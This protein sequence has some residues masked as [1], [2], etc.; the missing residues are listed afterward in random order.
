L[1]SE[2]V[3]SVAERM[4]RTLVEIGHAMMK[5]QS[6]LEFLWEYA[7]AHATYLRNRS[8]TKFLKEITPYQLW[9]N[10]KPN[11]SH[12]REFSAPVWVVLQGQNIP[13]KMLLKSKKRAY[14][15]YEDGSK[16]IKY[17]NA[18][19]RKILTSR[20]FCFLSNTIQ[21]PPEEI[22]VAPD[23]QHEGELGES[24]LPTGNN[25]LKRKRGIEEENEQKQI[26]HTHRKRVDYCYLND[27]FPD[28]TEE[29]NEIFTVNP[30]GGD[31]PKSLAEAKRSP[32]WDEWEKAV[33]KELDQLTEMGVW[34]LVDKPADAILISNRWV[35]AVLYSPPHCPVG[36]R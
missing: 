16:S 32:E 30:L 27:P 17:Y 28:E 33:T 19:T 29:I 14:V 10:L 9:Y 11:V 6:L 13:R 25:S 3:T 18:E 8:Y 7:I 21:S 20:N 22:E 35:F 4:N 36:V 15:G 5:G 23:S 34:K 2:V 26:S 24:M 1:L 31:D 12:L